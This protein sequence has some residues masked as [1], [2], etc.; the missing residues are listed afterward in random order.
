MSAD[1]QEMS[2]SELYEHH[3]NKAMD[4]SNFNEYYQQVMQHLSLDVQ[5]L[6]QEKEKVIRILSK[7][8]KLYN[9][10]KTPEGKNRLEQHYYEKLGMGKSKKKSKKKN[11]KK[12]K[13]KRGGRRGRKR[14][15]KRRR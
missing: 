11:K 6:T 7:K 15:T 1:E 14:R 12:S 10:L 5:T 4:P 2:M 13:K 8:S 9:L 3:F